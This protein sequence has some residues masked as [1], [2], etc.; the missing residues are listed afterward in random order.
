MEAGYDYTLM[1][2]RPQGNAKYLPALFV[3]VLAGVLLISGVAY[4]GFT[5]DARAD[6]A[7]Q[8]AVLDTVE[9]SS[10][11]DGETGATSGTVKYTRYLS[12]ASADEIAGQ[13]LYPAGFSDPVF[14]VNP[15]GY[16][17]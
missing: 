17:E 9:G 13:Q 7:A 6:Q 1:G 8:V 3:S 16:E 12:P 2:S 4:Y 15:L 14:W 5:S 10:V 11:G